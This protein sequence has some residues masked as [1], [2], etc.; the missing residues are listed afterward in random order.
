MT[1]RLHDGREWSQRADGAR[2]YPG[3]LTDAEL[4]AKFLGCAERSLSRR[5]ANWRSMRRAIDAAP[6]VTALTAMLK[7]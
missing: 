6:K 5:D 4:A 1:V 2:G 3:R 7:T